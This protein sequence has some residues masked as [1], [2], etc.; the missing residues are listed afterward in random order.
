MPVP[1]KMSDWDLGHSS[2]H[3]RYG[4]AVVFVMLALALQFLPAARQVP[5]A[6]FFAAVAVSARICGFG[7]AIFSTILSA[8]IES[9][10]DAIFN[11][12]LD[13]TVLT[14]NRAA[15][16]MYGYD[17]EEMIGRNVAVL[18]TP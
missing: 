4:T 18:A 1:A 11:K 17:P 12:T 9:S 8:A 14:W 3:V 7:A 5:F 10:E 16:E 2:W 6:F 15:Q 13:G